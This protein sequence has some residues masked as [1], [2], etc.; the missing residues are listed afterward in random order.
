MDPRISAQDLMRCD[1]CETAIVQMHCDTCLVNLCKACV[2]EHISI[3]GS[4]DHKVV[5]FQLKN[6]I[7]L[8]PECTS[9]EKE[10]CEMYCKHCDIPVCQTC[11]ASDQHLGHKLSKIL[12]VVSEKK[13]LIRKEQNE[14]KGTIYPTYQGI[15]AD[16]QNKMRQLEKEYGELSTAITKHGEDLHREIDKLVSKLKAQVEKMKTSQLQTLQ[17]Q[18][19]EI[20]KNVT[21][22]KDTLDI[23]VD[24]NDISKLC[25]VKLR[26]DQYKNLPQKH[27]LSVPKFTP[28]TTKSD[29]LC[30]LFG[31]LSSISVKSEEHGYR[32]TKS[33]KSPE[34]E[35]PEV[36]SPS[37][38]QK[39]LERRCQPV[40]PVKRFLQIPKIHS[41]SIAYFGYFLNVASLRNEQIWVCGSSKRM[42][43]Y[44]IEEYFRCTLDY[45]KPPLKTITT[46]SGNRPSDIAVS[47]S[48]YLINSDYMDRTVNIVENNS[49]IKAVIRLQKWRPGAVCSTSTNDL[50]V[51]LE[52][53]DRN[54]S[55][56]VRYSDFKEKQSIQFDHTCTPLYSSGFSLKYICENR[57][58]DICVA[59]CGARALVVVNQAG[60]FRFIYYGHTPSP[61]HQPFSPCGITTDSQ[62]HILTSDDNN[63]CVHI[64]NEDG[65]FLRFINCG[66]TFKLHGLCTNASDNLFVLSSRGYTFQDVVN[67]FRSDAN[68]DIYNVMKIKYLQ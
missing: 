37:F 28:G 66:E 24:S 67:F 26:V 16:T 31:D 5:N 15:A 58:L 25:S 18:L 12:N 60:K 62:C 21:D 9:H 13:D 6:S 46:K 51:T 33:Q 23:A 36:N 38:N 52:S 22:I 4:K 2:G 43:L 44:R 32:I 63:Y 27:V 8:F 42:D 29:E 3:A 10:Q 59:D 1:H 48:G 49:N 20:N 61:K 54:H 55:K 53:N 65:A 14:L 30:K 39:T 35:T 34:M 7:P 45:Q 68:S 19:D 11:L 41:E 47:R 56:V 64:L 50:L 40:R 57:N 17:T